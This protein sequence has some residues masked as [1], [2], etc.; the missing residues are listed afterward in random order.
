LNLE[1]SII[2]FSTRKPL[3]NGA[4]RVLHVLYR[5]KFWGRNTVSYATLENHYC[6]SVADFDDALQALLELG[7]IEMPGR[8][9]AISLQSSMREDIESYL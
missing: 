7:L 2:G 4:R 9:A 5:K 6:K 8:R 3:S 1:E